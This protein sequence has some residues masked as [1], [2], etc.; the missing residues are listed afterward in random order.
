MPLGKKRHFVLMVLRSGEATGEEVHEDRDQ[1]FPIAVTPRSM[2]KLDLDQQRRAP[3]VLSGLM[4]VGSRVKRRHEETEM[5]RVGVLR[6][7]RRAWRMHELIDALEV[8]RGKLVRLDGGTA[9]AQARKRCLFCG[10]SDKCLRWLGQARLPA[11]SPTFCP[12][13]KLFEACARTPSSAG[14]SA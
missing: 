11:S 5:E 6:V 10:T 14:S 4:K 7:E 3:H 8:D 2:R 12:N 1:F 13:L 9:Y